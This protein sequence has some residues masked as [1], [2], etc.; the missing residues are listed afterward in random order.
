MNH[1]QINFAPLKNQTPQFYIFRK[2]AKP[3]ERK[4]DFKEFV[5][6]LYSVEESLSYWYSFKELD[7][8]E[9][10]EFNEDNLANWR[11]KKLWLED[12]LYSLNQTLGNRTFLTTRF[13][14]RLNFILENHIE[15]K[16]VVW[17]EP[18][19]LKKNNLI[20]F[21]INF[22]FFRNRNKSKE[23][24][25][26]KEL[27]LSLALTKDFKVNKNYH[28]DLYTKIRQFARLF[29]PEHFKNS[30]IDFISLA[31][32][33]SPK[34]AAKHYLFKNK[35]EGTSQFNG[36]RENGPYTMPS[37]I[38]TFIFCFK[39]GE[40]RLIKELV[41]KLNGIG[42]R[43]FQGF[44]KIFKTQFHAKYLDITNLGPEDIINTIKEKIGELENCV[45]VFVEPTNKE[46]D[47]INFYFKVKFSSLNKKLPVQFIQY[48]NYR[49]IIYDFEFCTST[50][51]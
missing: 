29:Y 27:V 28:I 7:G 24:Q 15:G 3:E 45:A 5:K 17:I 46:K 11:I 36:L 49:K 35:V 22:R 39:K 1:L 32:L 38:P 33:E 51:C 20:G 25:T 43:T 4:K 18:Y 37:T 47:S 14:F 30:P 6:K 23:P 50:F 10:I 19:Y 26:N 42:D 31:K 9:R 41:N 34:L 40:E 2:I 13:N 16:E 12:Q 8:F 44:E 21:L 48:K